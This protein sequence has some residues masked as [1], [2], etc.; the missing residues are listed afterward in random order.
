[1][2]EIDFLCILVIERHAAKETSVGVQSAFTWGF[3]FGNLARYGQR[4][5]AST[6]LLA[7]QLLFIFEPRRARERFLMKWMRDDQMAI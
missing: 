7:L 1:M 6:D 2:R 5:M 3:H 4:H